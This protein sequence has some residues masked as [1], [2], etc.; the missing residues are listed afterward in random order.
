MAELVA[1]TDAAD[2]IILAFPLY[3]DSLPAGVIRV[4]E[5]IAKHRLEQKLITSQRF[6]AICNCGFPESN[7]IDPALLICKRFAA[8]AGMK[9]AGGLALGGGEAIHG[10][11]LVEAGGRGRY[12]VQALDLAADALARGESVPR[13]AS[14]LM[15]KPIIPSWLY[16]LFG[17]HGWKKEA[18]KYGTL[19]ELKARPYDHE[20]QT[21]E[22]AHKP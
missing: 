14:K 9:W 10:E 21:G 7:H 8:E 20:V 22:T 6:V 3:I 5:A 2:L 4:L 18:G 1:A 15:A 19:R 16:R 11:H 17:Q 13:E 12:A